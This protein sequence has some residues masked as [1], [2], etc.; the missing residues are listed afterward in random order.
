VALIQKIAAGEALALREHRQAT[1]APSYLK[2]E[3]YMN[4]Q[5]GAAYDLVSRPGAVVDVLPYAVDADGRLSVYAK[6]AYP[7]PVVNSQ[8]RQMS[9]NID[10]K[11]WSGHMVEPLAAANG[12]GDVAASVKALL[13][14]R[15]PFTAAQIK[16]IEPA[17]SY[18]TAPA[19]VNERVSSVF[20]RLEGAPYE[21]A[22]RGSFSRFS[23][24]GNVRAFDAQ[25]LLRS[26]Q[27]GMLPE[28][29][30]EMN[31]YALMRRLH[32]APE[33]W[34]GDTYKVATAPVT[35]QAGTP[36]RRAVF[37]PSDTPAHY[38]KTLRSVF[39]EEGQEKESR[40]VLTAQEFEFAVP[41]RRGGKDVST[42][43]AMIVPLIR[44]AATGEIMIGL[45]DRDFPAVQAQD[46][47]SDMTT[48]PGLRL[49]SAV[50]GLAEARSYVAAKMGVME[51]DV[52]RLGESYFPSMGIMPNRAFP[53]I[54][55]GAAL[56]DNPR[57][58]FKPL[59]EVFAGIEDCRDAHLT[60][61]VMRTV[62]ALGLW[63]D[64]TQKATPAMK[65]APG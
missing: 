48:I 2:L 6:C 42:N 14:E 45:E 15:T 8:P 13:D 12:D 35:V 52:A 51:G 58:H 55:S 65:R 16:A 54:V 59:R 26:V 46:G 31:L 41:D 11:V 49:P 24:D 40:T 50:T 20:V 56:T 18:Y 21:G 57:L 28:A 25:D 17:M 64:Y 60:V 36:A 7:R 30:L 39:V 1:D 23:S 44:D 4:A 47:H 32:I 22:L 10:G 38:L 19:D 63:Q 9:P 53:Y 37:N 62:H 33:G 3:H 29:R 61:A 43:S 27:V 34:I 5:T